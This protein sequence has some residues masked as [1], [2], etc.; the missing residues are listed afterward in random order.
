MLPVALTDLETD[1][2][3]VKLF[4]PGETDIGKF[5]YALEENGQYIFEEEIP[6][7]NKPGTYNVAWLFEGDKN[8]ADLGDYQHGFQY[9]V[10]VKQ[11]ETPVP[12][13][14]ENNSLPAWAIAL[15]CVG[16]GL[17]LVG[18]ILYVRSRRKNK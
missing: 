6:S 16:G 17:L 15:I 14:P 5:T 2:E 1:G 18:A 12:P 3:A 11:K 13:T 4:K 8:H 10:V 9:T 7:V